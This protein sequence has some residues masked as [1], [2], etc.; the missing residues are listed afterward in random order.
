MATIVETDFGPVDIDTGETQPV[1]GVAIFNPAIRGTGPNANPVIILAVRA[2]DPEIL[3][4]ND[5]G[6]FVWVDAHNIT[7]DWRYDFTKGEWADI[8][9]EPIES[10]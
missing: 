3:I 6:R 9:G 1:S 7:A 10:E 2:I 5:E 4:V 8:N